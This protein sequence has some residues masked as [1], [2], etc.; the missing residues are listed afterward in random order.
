MAGNLIGSERRE[1]VRRDGS[2][3]KGGGE[4]AVEGERTNE[5]RERGGNVSVI[6]EEN[7]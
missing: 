2:R 4:E 6:P 7:V 3:E 1:A 5:E